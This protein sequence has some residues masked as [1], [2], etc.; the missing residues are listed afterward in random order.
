MSPFNK[1]LPASPSRPRPQEREV[2][3]DACV[4][5]AT[6]GGR[7]KPSE[8]QPAAA[9]PSPSPGEGDDASL[10]FLEGAGGGRL[11]WWSSVVRLLM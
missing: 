9:P 7:T 8:E 4:V 6:D 2:D 5:C 1:S 10:S 3:F 11:P